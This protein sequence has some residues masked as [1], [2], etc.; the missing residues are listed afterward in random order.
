VWEEKDGC[1][2]LTIP[3]WWTQ[4]ARVFFS[5]RAGGAS[6]GP[7]AELNLGLHVGDEPGQVAQNRDKLARAVGL[8]DY[9]WY[10][11]RQVHGNDVVVVDAQAA[12]TPS[13]PSALGDADGIATRR[14]GAV[15]MGFF[16]DCAP[17]FF[18]APRRQVVALAHAGWRGTVGKVAQEAVYRLEQEFD[19]RRGDLQVAIGPCIGVCCYQ[20]GAEVIELVRERFGSAGEAFL[21]HRNNALYLDLAGLNRFI[22]VAAG[23]PAQS[24]ITSRYCTSCHPELFFSHRREAGKTGRMAG[25]IALR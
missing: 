4:G 8:A 22:L 13:Q 20:V 11:A 19:C 3:R 17:L 16:A 23:V 25:G 9:A 21:G 14:R 2:F 12:G 6:T 18:F 10:A 1:R 5:S 24:I 15:L 7:W